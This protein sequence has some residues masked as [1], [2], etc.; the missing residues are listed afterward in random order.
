MLWN[1]ALA[2]GWAIYVE[3]RLVAA[4]FGGEGADGDR[5]RLISAKM[6]LRSIANAM[7]DQGMHV[8]GWSDDEAMS[9]M[10]DQTFQE[11]AEAEAKLL[12]AKTTAGQVSTYFVGGEEMDDLRRDAE[13]ARG[14]TFDAAQFHAD[15][16]AEGTPPFP[17][18]RRAI[19]K[20]A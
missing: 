12:R 10:L 13:A 16:L 8:H 15:V 1:S 20:E 9:L 7:L 2:E 19:L 14:D 4:G 6:E 5:M 3:R 18:L 11:Q 17:V